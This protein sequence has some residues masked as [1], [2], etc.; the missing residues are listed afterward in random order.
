MAKGIIYIM[1][2]AVNG[3][4]KI[5][6]T[7]DFESRMRF[8]ENNGYYNVVGFKR[9]FAI[10]VENYDE[11]EKLIHNLFSK[12]R[13]SDSEL[14]AVDV[15]LVKSLLSALDGKVIYP[16]DERKEEIFIREAE[17]VEVKE[18]IIPDGR[19]TYVTKVKGYSGEV[20]AIMVV[21]N[22]KLY[23]EAGSKLAPVKSITTKGWA[24]VRDSIKMNDLVTEERVEC[25]TPSMVAEIAV[26]RSRNGWLCWKNSS[27]QTIDV[28]RRRE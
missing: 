21:E 4:I 3:L 8:I 11:K 12:S 1:V 14:F 15:S 10:E 22:G 9:E 6:K 16:T 28:Y 26:G 19:Y 27:G 24:E 17:I 25:S 13:V 7:T 5:G 18:G 2:S 20:A 23:L